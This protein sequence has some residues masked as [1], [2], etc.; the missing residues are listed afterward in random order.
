M[1]VR[2]GRIVAVDIIAD[3]DRLRALDLT[4]LDG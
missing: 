4:V 1:T 3:P 2:D